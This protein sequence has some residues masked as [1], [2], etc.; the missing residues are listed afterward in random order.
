MAEI[1]ITEISTEDLPMS[2]Q[3]GTGRKRLKVFVRG[4]S[5]AVTDTLD[6]STYVKGLA[7]I[8]GLSSQSVA[9][10]TAATSATFSGTT[11]TFAGHASTG[12]TSLEATCYLN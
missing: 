10:A 11:I 3:N 1:T 9:G 12:V 8:E 2:V 7:G 5:A 4:T 6:L